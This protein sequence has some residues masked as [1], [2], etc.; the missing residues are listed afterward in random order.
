M[1]ITKEKLKEIEN[2][3]IKQDGL[4]FF[5]DH[6]KPILTNDLTKDIKLLVNNT[7]FYP[8]FSTRN[9]KEI[10]CMS[11]KRRSF[12]DMFL[13]VKFYYPDVT[14]KEIRDTLLDLGREKFLA[15]TYCENIKKRVVVNPT[16]P[17]GRWSSYN[18]VMFSEETVDE[19]GLTLNDTYEIY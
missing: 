9:P 2:R 5:A 7:Q 8:T 1:I 15:I 11:S 18:T 19:H 13:L 14:F 3:L 16:N 10:Q 12:G 6:H 17:E 4:L